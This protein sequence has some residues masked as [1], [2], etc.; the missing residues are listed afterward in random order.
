MPDLADV[1]HL[2]KRKHMMG[3]QEERAWDHREMELLQQQEEELQKKWENLLAFE[4]RLEVEASGT[5]WQMFLGN[6]F[7][8]SKMTTA[9]KHAR[10]VKAHW[11]ATLSS[12]FQQT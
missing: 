1:E 5:D 10:I 6:P 11:F 7:F 9:Q 4:H 3:V 8:R 2:E 12:V